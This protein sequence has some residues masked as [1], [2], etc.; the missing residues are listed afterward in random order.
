VV[1]AS[2]HVRHQLDEEQMTRR[3]L[4][5]FANP[6]MHILGHATGRLINTREPYA[7]NMDAILDEA[8]KRGVAIEVNGNPHRLDIKADYIRKAVQRGV[9]LVVSTDAH[10]VDELSNFAFSVGTARKGWAEKKDVLNT[11]PLQDFMR[12]LREGRH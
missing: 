8:A 7:L 3:I 1:I 11:L 6:H 5:A 4:R 9:K 12:R 2:I 10:S